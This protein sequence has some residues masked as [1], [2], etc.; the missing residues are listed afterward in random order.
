MQDTLHTF[1]KK[2]ATLVQLLPS[3]VEPIMKLATFIGLP[4]II[5]L[6]ASI[7]AVI[8]WMKG[9]PRIAYAQ[10]ASV[11]ALGAD[12]ILKYA[13][14]RPRPKTL[15]VENMKIHSYSFPSGHA[16]GAVAFYGLVAY[17]AYKYLPEPVNILV[18]VVLIILIV[19][20]GVSRI[21]LGAH[22]PSDVVGGWLLGGLCLLMIIKFIN[23]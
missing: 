12:S 8:S 22:F 16:F 10:V 19:L 13:V 6:L 3:W 17:L 1:D 5:I 9:T 11:V 4:V 23:P 21:Y 15:Y 14:H 7:I 2:A 20:I 18:T